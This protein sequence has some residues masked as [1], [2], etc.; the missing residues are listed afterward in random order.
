MVL[1]YRFSIILPR[2]LIHSFLGHQ[3]SNVN[4]QIATASHELAGDILKSPFTPTDC[5]YQDSFGMME[6]RDIPGYYWSI[7]SFAHHPILPC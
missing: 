6:R 3:V 2:D 1:S 4:N 7:Y 5:P